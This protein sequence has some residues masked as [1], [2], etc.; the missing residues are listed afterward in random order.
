MSKDTEIVFTKGEL[1]MVRL[2]LVMAR[3]RMSDEK[4]ANQITAIIGKIDW[5]LSTPAYAIG[6]LGAVVVPLHPQPTEEEIKQAQFRYY[7][8]ILNR[9]EEI[10]S[11]RGF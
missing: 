2:I 3:G 11:Q 5:L 1:D 9:E 7:T 4:V 10:R 8:D 6:S